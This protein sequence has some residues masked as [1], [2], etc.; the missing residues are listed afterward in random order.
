MRDRWIVAGVTLALLAGSAAEA[1]HRQFSGGER[2]I[3]RREIRDETATY[4]DELVLHVNA[5]RA[6][7]SHLP[8]P[9]DGLMSINTLNKVRLPRGA[10]QLCTGDKFDL[11][12]GGSI[13]SMVGLGDDGETI[14]QCTLG[15]FEPI[16]EVMLPE[17]RQR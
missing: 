7:I 15:R 1:R 6:Y 11:M 5:G 8:H 9:C 13:Q 4:P 10:D 12:D 2:C 17:S 14:T 16:Q 3:P